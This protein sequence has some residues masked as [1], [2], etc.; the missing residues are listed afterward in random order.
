MSC[1]YNVKPG[2]P[3]TV[4][5]DQESLLLNP[6]ERK[7]VTGTISV[8]KNTAFTSYTGEICVSCSDATNQAGTVVKQDVCSNALAVKVVSTRT[9]DNMYIPSEEKPFINKTM[10]VIGSIVFLIGLAIIIFI[11]HRKKK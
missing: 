4:A 8:P 5:F 9:K 1:S 2:F 7:D 10:L 3:L 11:S 6:G